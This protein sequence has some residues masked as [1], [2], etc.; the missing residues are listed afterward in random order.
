MFSPTTVLADGDRKKV[1][2]RPGNPYRSAT[3]PLGSNAIG[4]GTLYRVTNARACRRPST[5]SI[6]TKVTLLPTA[7]ATLAIA[8]VSCLQ[9]PHV[10]DQKFI[11]IALTASPARVI[12]LLPPMRRSPH[13][14]ARP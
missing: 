8:G 9:G 5:V 13:T 14:L 7:R 11:T 10:E 1:T 12:V 4:Y 2:G 6:P 3:V